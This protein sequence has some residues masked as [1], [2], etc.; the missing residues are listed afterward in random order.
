MELVVREWGVVREFDP[1]K[2]YGYVTGQ[3][4]ETFFVHRC[5]LLDGVRTLREGQT[6]EFDGV[7]TERGLRAVNVLVV[8][9]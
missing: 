7:Q 4:G 3:T 2:C 8:E 5:D 9:D 6:V 1:V